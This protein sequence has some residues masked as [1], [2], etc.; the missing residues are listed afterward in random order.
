MTETLERS[1]AFQSAT[2]ARAEVE[3]WLAAFE[4][5]LTA[6]DTRAAA[7]M[8]LDDSY[9]RDLVSFT[10]NIKTVEGPD[11]IRAMLDATLAQVQPHGFTLADEPAEADGI[12][13]GWL[14][15]RDIGRAWQ[16]PPAAQGRQGL[17]AADHALRAHRPRGAGRAEPPDGRRAR[18]QQGPPDVARG[19]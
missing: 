16:R 11:E 7:A 8:F 19:P 10:W 13:D 17:D 9:W 15:F 3:A 2:P 12:T 14:E 1:S 6:G 4:Q 18:R 5:A